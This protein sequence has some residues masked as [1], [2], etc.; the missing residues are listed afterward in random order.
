MSVELWLTFGTLVGVVALLATERV[1]IALVALVAMSVLA[2]TGVITT[3]EALAGLA[4]P[5]TVT[6][7]AMFVI[8]AS[9][10]RSGVLETGSAILSTALRR[11]QHL[12]MLLLL[13]GTAVASAFVNN[14]AVVVVMM[15]LVV[16]A[17]RRAEI[18][19]SKLLIPLSFASMLGGTCTLIGTSTNLLVDT[20]AQ[21]QGLAPIGMFELAPVGLL[22]TLGGGAFVLWGVPRLLPGRREGKSSIDDFEIRGYL[23]DIRVPDDPAW[24]GRQLQDAPVPGRLDCDVLAL[25]GA[26]REHVSPTPDTELRAGDILRLRCGLQDI[27]RLLARSDIAVVTHQLGDVEL[28]DDNAV[29]VEA[30][31]T[32]DGELDGREVSE[33]ELTTRHGAVLLAIRHHGELRRSEMAGACLRGGDVVLMRV[34]RDKLPRLQR[35]DVFAVVTQAELEPPRPHKIPVALGILVAVVLSAS[36]GWLPV[37]VAAVAGAVAAVVSGCLRF[38]EALRAV[39]LR[40]V[41][42]LAGLL[43]LASAMHKTG[44]AELIAQAVLSV[45]ADGAGIYGLVAALYVVTVALTSVVSNN[46]TAAV[47]TPIAIGMAHDVGVDPRPLVVTVAF[48]AS[49]SFLTPLGYQTNTLVYNAGHYRFADFLRAGTPLTL[50]VLGLAV[51]AIP[52]VWPG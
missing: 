43:A 42:L 35:S 20:M 28:D 26:G 12:G 39:R 50:L 8:S 33:A 44:A 3:E 49:T 5:A 16:A 7:A 22:L 14:T 15:P 52:L 36:L 34:G 41:L 27:G 25:R 1:P 32:P 31:I 2:V 11:H 23:L 10:R 30:V 47:M 29:F 13:G 9:V 45:A 6:V 51:L 38:D 17:A 48:A 24:A 19:A 21:Q 18:S 4:S 46:G 37:A 40:I